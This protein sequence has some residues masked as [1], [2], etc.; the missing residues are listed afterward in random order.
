MTF[1]NLAI[2]LATSSALAGVTPPASAADWTL[3]F[4]GVGPLKIGMTFVQANAQLQRRLRRTP[5][6]L[7]ASEFCDYLETPGHPG[8]NLMFVNDK[9]AR[10]DVSRTGARIRGG[11]VIGGDESSLLPAYSSATKAPGAYDASETEWT[12]PSPDG[13]MAIRIT[14][15]AHHIAGAVGG[16]AKSVGYIE[17]CN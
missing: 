10:V 5:D 3:R 11:V 4:D 6:D 17:E 9:L 13:R 15:A 7:R 14:T 2:A 8:I 12:L 1:R 16:D